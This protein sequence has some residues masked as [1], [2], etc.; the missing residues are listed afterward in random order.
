MENKE[1]KFNQE[2]SFLND[3]IILDLDNQVNEIISSEINPKERQKLL[4]KLKEKWNQVQKEYV[5]R[6]VDDDKR[7]FLDFVSYNIRKMSAGGLNM[8]RSEI[9]NFIGEKMKELTP[10]F[11]NFYGT[12]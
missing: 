4:K 1:P 7:R 11:E 3:E 5:G 6:N 10:Y 2:F 9:S 8:G 12:P